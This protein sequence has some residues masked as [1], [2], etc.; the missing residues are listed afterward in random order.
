MADKKFGASLIAASLLALL[1]SSCEYSYSQAPLE[2]STPLPTGL[3]VSPLPPADNPM[4]MIEE[5]ATG[6]AIAQTAA[7]ASGTPGTPQAPGT[8]ITPETGLTGTPTAT[9]IAIL[10]TT[11]TPATP[12]TVTPTATLVSIT[13]GQGRPATYTLQQGEF[14]YCIARRYNVN[15][16][17]LLALN[18]LSRGDIYYPNLVLKMPQTGNPFPGDRSWHDHPATFTVGVTY[19]TDTIYGVAC[20]YGDIEPAVIAQANGLSLT[21]ALTSGQV[22]DIP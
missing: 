5:Y 16:D 10:G 9:P 19:D 15:P 3:F 8:E 4:T 11:E 13:G 14:P 17:E 18:N 20:Y 12:Q 2:T 22:L 6:T 7:A 21:A 1:L